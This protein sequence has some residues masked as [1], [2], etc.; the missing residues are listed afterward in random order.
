MSVPEVTGLKP[1]FGPSTGGT[2]LTIRGSNLGSDRKDI[3]GQWL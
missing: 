1:M 2:H 3:M